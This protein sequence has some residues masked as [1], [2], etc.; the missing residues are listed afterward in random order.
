MSKG[1]R[2]QPGSRKLEA[3]LVEWGMGKHFHRVHRQDRS[4]QSLNDRRDVDARFSPIF[5][6][7]GALIPTLYAGSTL[8][9]AFMETIFRNV[10]F[11]AGFKSVPFSALVG[12]AHS[13]IVPQNNLTLIDLSVIAL[14]K[15]GI[16]RK[17]LVDTDATCYPR[18]HRWAEALY[19]QY[20][21]AKG[22][23]WIS[24]QDDA[25]EAVILF[26]TRIKPDEL[27]PKGSP[28]GL[29]NDGHA[30]AE[31]LR[32]AERLNVRLVDAAHGRRLMRRGSEKSIHEAK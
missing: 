15:L 1:E 23:R 3:T 13:V 27:V 28:I 6:R 18:C 24:R 14:H 9:C 25:A 2:Y 26:G 17:H 21:E 20:P 16:D 22:L 29:L 5:D 12:R 4:P 8:D 7:S 30:I 19:E 10:P 31:V 11:R 32:L